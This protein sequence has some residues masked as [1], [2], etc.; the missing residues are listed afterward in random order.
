MTDNK[1]PLEDVPATDEAS[2]AK[3]PKLE[4][5][6]APQETSPLAQRNSS[7]RGRSGRGGK[8]SNYKGKAIKRDYAPREPKTEPDDGEKRLPKR[9]VCVL[10]G[11]CG[12]GLSG[13]QM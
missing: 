2:E 12:T 10:I 4:T 1:R 11:Y 6:E 13:S 3:K 8:G 7:Q 9:K 5:S